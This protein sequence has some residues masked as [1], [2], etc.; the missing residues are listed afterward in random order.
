PSVTG[1][2]LANDADVDDST[3][4]PTPGQPDNNGSY[5]FTPGSLASYVTVSDVTG[6]TNVAGVITVTGTYGTLVMNPDGDYTYTLD[7]SLLATQALN[8]GDTPTE[9]F[10]YTVSDNHPDGN[11]KTATAELVITVFGDND[12]PTGVNNTAAVE[13][14]TTTT[15]AG[16][17]I[18]NDT[19]PSGDNTPST[20]FEVVA[21]G[22]AAVS[23]GTTSLNGAT[24]TGSYGSLTIGA[25]GSYTYTLNNGT[26]GDGTNAVQRLAEG[27]TVTE[28]FTY[29]VSDGVD[30][31]KS[32]NNDGDFRV[33]AF[34][35][36]PT[37]GVQL[38]STTDAFG[39]FEAVPTVGTV[40]VDGNAYN[41]TAVETDT[42]DV[43]NFLGAGG[44][45][46]HTGNVDY[47]TIGGGTITDNDQLAV[48][49]QTYL[50]FAN[51]GTYSI[52]ARSDDG[53]RLQLT[54][55]TAPG[56]F[57][58]DSA[59]GQIDDGYG[60]GNDTLLFEGATGNASSIGVFTVT[61]GQ[62]LKLDALFWENFSGDAFE[63]AIASGTVT[64]HTSTSF[65]LLTDGVL[66]IELSSD[67]TF[68]PC[69]TDTATLTVTITGD[70]DERVTVSDANA[71]YEDGVGG[72]SVVTGDVDANDTE[73]DIDANTPN[74]ALGLTEVVFGTGTPVTIPS[75]G[76]N[77]N[78]NGLYG[79]LSINS[80]GGYS[81]SVNNSLPAVQALDDGQN[82]TETFTYSQVDGDGSTITETLTI[83]VHGENDEPVVSNVSAGPELYTVAGSGLNVAPAGTITDIDDPEMESL[84]VTITNFDPSQDQLRVDPSFTLPVGVTVNVTG[85]TLTISSDTPDTITVADYE[86]I[87][88][89]VQYVN[90]I[91]VGNG[92][93]REIEIVVS[94]GE[95]NS[96]LVTTSVRLEVPEP[97]E[98]VIPSIVEEREVVEN[99][100]VDTNFGSGILQGF[101]YAERLSLVEEEVEPEAMPILTVSPMYSGTAEPGTVVTVKVLGSNGESL[102]NGAMSV[103]ADMSG[104]WLA[105]F[106]DLELPD[107]HHYVVVEQTAPTWQ[108]DEM[109]GHRALKAY[110]APSINQGVSGG[111]EDFGVAGVYGRRLSGIAI[112]QLNQ[113]ALYPNA[114]ANADWRLGQGNSSAA[115]GIGG[116]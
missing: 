33:D 39:I 114:P 82:V 47:E 61:A 101:R 79:S 59:S 62:T 55:P 106:P 4:T 53:R 28:T 29:T 94:D 67:A 83:T 16:N 60:A 57:T 97:P 2:V 52:V 103:V 81:Y 115:S 23:A 12:S 84:S 105:I 70:N 44:N 18:T 48:R 13:E 77:V 75:N 56:A 26:D 42:M 92:P 98:E 80:S 99:S 8:I 22:S 100:E 90:T 87:L 88:Q 27:E 25:D 49:A 85:G 111:Q 14:D 10:T 32:P 58:F 112:D 9:S 34:Q 46:R 71:A 15:A 113:S 36:Q 104:N 69:A 19:S 41:V 24:A 64:N 38:R 93:D 6:G 51:A 109:R 86:S 110:F 108:T 76:N 35:V 89:A 54:D 30:M 45:D 7:D 37:G 17:V 40:T 107:Q 91:A 96:Q 3:A 116:I 73:I 74:D 21:I 43:I 68:E 72:A 78:V 95:E 20:D 65:A 5:Y 66:G 102:S 31:F 50:T 63:I 1:N 11:V